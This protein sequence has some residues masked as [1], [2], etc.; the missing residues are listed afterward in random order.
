MLIPHL[1]RYLQNL[2][3]LLTCSNQI[4]KF[5]FKSFRFKVFNIKFMK[6][7]RIKISSLFI[8]SDDSS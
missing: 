4:F 7:A 5:K 8:D 3:I 6:C 2:K 1:I